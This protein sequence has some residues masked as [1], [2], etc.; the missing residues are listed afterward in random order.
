MWNNFVCLAF[1]TLDFT[2]FRARSSTKAVRPN[3]TLESGGHVTSY[4]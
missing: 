2:I 3:K 4:Y 1:Q